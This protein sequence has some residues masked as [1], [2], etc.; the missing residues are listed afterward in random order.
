[1]IKALLI[2]PYPGLAE[3]VKQL[4]QQENELYINIGIG[5]LEEGVKLARQAEKDGY[6][7]II[8]RG[9]TATLIQE[10]VSLPVVH[11][12]V[13][14]YDMLRVF[15]LV[16]GME[17]GVALVGFPNIS[18]GAA[19]I[20]NI[21]EF[22][23]KMIT[24][25]SS[26]EV[27]GHLEALKE[28]GYTLV[29]GDVVTVQAAEQV[30]LRGILITSGK[31]AV[32]TAFEEAKRIYSLFNK[33]KKQTAHIIGAFQ[34]LPLPVVILDKAG[35]HIEQNRFYTEE[36]PNS[37]L[38]ES[39]AA[40]ALIDKVGKKQT[41]DWRTIESNGKT[42]ILQAFPIEQNSSLI[43]TV[44]RPTYLNETTS[45]AINV[46]SKPPHV[47]IIGESTMAENLRN[48]IRSYAKMA[49]SIWI[50]GEEGTG[51][52]TVAQAIH[53]ERYG[54]EAPIIAIK[55]DRVTED[56]LRLLETKSAYTNFHKGTLL[57]Q[58][59]T[60]LAPAA[61]TLLI[62][63]IRQ[64]PEDAKVISVSD[65]DET[66]ETLNRELYELLAETTLHLQP[67]RERKQDIAAFVHY[68]LADFHANQG[69]ETL[70]IKTE[71]LEQLQQF[72]WPGNMNQLKQAVRELSVRTTG[73]YVDPEVVKGIINS[74]T[75]YVNAANSPV[76]SIK[77]TM[78]DMEQEIMKRVLAE[79]GMNQSKAA[80]RLGINRST[81]WRKLNH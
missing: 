26:E 38:I 57:L 77:G 14:G 47:P 67:L 36:I 35:N 63:L 7:L 50:Y 9:G 81:L 3:T 15:T 28:T 44:I 72:D 73:Y 20:C 31:E 22:D 68:F 6:D 48:S 4:R 12:D 37:Q 30:G 69:S 61:Q 17:T 54:Q 74:R 65:F 53:F 46:K 5:N 70:G 42:Y 79:E 33:I 58:N 1:M 56:D 29:M 76:I 21:L 40:Q 49:D 10:E 75:S 64:K 80:K 27:K 24:I 13:T 59:V 71:A 52:E 8:S 55:G 34:S 25:Q 2:A 39:E 51:K 78:A 66:G 23:V 32:L 62:Q 11:I 19:T 60:R 16:R 45:H 43:G 18:Q 41:T